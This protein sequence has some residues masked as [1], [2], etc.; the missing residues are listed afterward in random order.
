VHKEKK[1]FDQ[2]KKLVLPRLA[3]FDL[4]AASHF[5]NL[6][7]FPSSLCTKGASLLRLRIAWRCHIDI[8]LVGDIRRPLYCICP[9][10]GFGGCLSNCSQRPPRRTPVLLRKST[11]SPAPESI[12]VLTRQ[13]HFL[14]SVFKLLSPLVF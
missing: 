6:H 12:S 8:V 10:F 14:S 13:R 1:C 7:S 4:A 9:C 5:M 2:K 11:G 3:A